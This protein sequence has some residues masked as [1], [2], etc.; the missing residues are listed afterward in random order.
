MADNVDG[1]PIRHEKGNFWKQI[2]NEVAA[3][4]TRRLPTNKRLLVVGDS[5]SGKTSLISKLRTPGDDNYKK[6]AGLKY[7]YLDVHDEERDEHTRL[8]VWIQD[9]SS[10]FNNLLKFVFTSESVKDLMIAICVDMC[11][12]WRII[13]SL[14]KWNRILHEHLHSLHLPA[15]ELNAMEA[16]LSNDFQA[17]RDVEIDEEKIKKNSSESDELNTPLGDKVLTSNL[18]IPIIVIV[19]KSDH[20]TTLEKDYRDEHFD[21]IQKNIREFCLKC[22]AALLYTSSKE[23]CNISTLYKYILHRLYGFPLR[24]PPQ[25]ID[26]DAI[27]IPMGWDNINKISILNEHIKTFNSNDSFKDHI[28]KPPSRKTTTQDKEIIAEDEQSFLEAQLVALNNAIPAASTAVSQRPQIPAD[29]RNPRIPT[30]LSP[31]Q[32]KG[33]RPGMPNTKTKIDPTKGAS[34]PNSSETVL[35]NFFNSLLNKNT[36]GKTLKS[37][38]PALGTSRSD[39]QAELERM[40]KSTAVE[41]ESDA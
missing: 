1:V 22:G 6:G 36:T 35:A 12:P 30:S 7:T 9:G 39:V 32:H 24:V 38:N 41:K 25:I 4:A 15:K 34:A 19:T 16:K 2:L 28:K 20:M 10:H 26:K 29:P 11:K 31:G 8:N 13:D 27:F 14:E 33:P 37:A 17:Y 23:S 3:Q 18:G 21:F 5:Y 40:S